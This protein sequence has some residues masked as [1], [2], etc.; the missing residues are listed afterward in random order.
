MTLRVEELMARALDGRKFNRRALFRPSLVYQVTQKPFWVWCEYHAPTDQA[1]DETGRYDEM[2]LRRGIEFEQAWVGRH[3]PDAV[4]IEP[5]FGLEAL[6]NTFRAMIRGVRAIYQPHLWDLGR[7][8]YGKG[9]LL[10]R[11]DSRTSDLGPY[12]YRM[13]EIKNSRALQGHH[14]LQA[15]FYNRMLGRLQGYVPTEMTIALRDATE[16]VAYGGMEAEIEEVVSLWAALRDGSSVPEPGRPPDAASTPW[17]VYANNRVHRSRDLVLLAG[18]G[19]GERERLRGAGISSV[20][21][22]WDL[23]LE[24]VKSLVGEARGTQTYWVAQAYKSAGPLLKPGRALR[25]PR[26]RRRLYFDFET[27]DELHGKEPPH[28]Y[29]IGCWDAGRDQY[30]KFLARGAQDEERIFLEFLDYAGDLEATVLY[31]WT[32][33]EIREMKKVAGR[34]P[35]LEGSLER[36]ISRC[37]DIKAEIQSAVCL[38]VPTFSLKSVAPCLGFRWRQ[39][40]IGAFEAM[41]CY[42]DYLDGDAEAI[43]KAVLYNEDDCVAM[44]HVDEQLARRLE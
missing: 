6:S 13:V 32:D 3:Y 11:D 18:V 34:W 5:D 36:L 4:K 35:A 15:A 27:Y 12:H 16:N 8:S 1:V 21:R 7:A 41:V 2:R 9:D 43:R 26:G 17:R 40:G 44:W 39:E 31:H 38:P 22:L 33:F 29:L 14:M 42:W 25:V 28:I 20:D 30:V 37:V 10:V 19:R 24:E 23:A